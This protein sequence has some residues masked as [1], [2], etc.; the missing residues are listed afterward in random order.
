[1]IE[2]KVGELGGHKGLYST[3]TYDR[4]IFDRLYGGDLYAR[5]KSAYD[6]GGRLPT[7]YDKAVR[8]R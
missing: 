2:D 6:A 8:G 7:L 5:V 4:T 3:A 1:M